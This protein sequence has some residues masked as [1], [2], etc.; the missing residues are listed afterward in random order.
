[1]RQFLIENHLQGALNGSVNLGLY[2]SD[3]TLVCLSVFGKTRYEQRDGYELYRFC[4]KINYTVVGG[5]NK[6]L[7]H[8]IKQYNA[9]YLSSYI[10]LR[11]FTGNGYKKAGFIQQSTSRAN[12]YYF[13]LKDSP[14][15]LKS[16]VGFQKHKL[17]KMF[18]N[19]DPSLSEY[20]NMVQN[21]YSRIFDAGNIKFVY[22]QGNANV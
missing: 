9:K 18:A 6:I 19:F 7:K 13:K 4:N 5:F 20:E 16:R 22:M 12:Y 11:Y 21:G 2:N 3:D 8:F 15:V 14:I 10:D 1:M 17:E